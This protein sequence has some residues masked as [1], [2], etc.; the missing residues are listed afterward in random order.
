MLASLLI[1]FR[2]VLEA[3]LIVGIVLAATRGIAG[4]GAWIAGGIGGGVLGAA[5]L[6]I[7]AGALSDAFAGSGQEVFNAAVLSIA[8][9]MLGWHTLWMARHGREMAQHM[10]TMGVAVAIGSRSLFALAIVVASAVLRE[11]AE[12]VLFLYGIAAS[13]KEGWAPVLLGGVLGI[14]GGGLVSFLLYRGLVAI[15][16]GRLFGVTGWLVAL[17]A[18]GMASQAAAFLVKANLIPSWGD[19]IWDTSWLLSDG[20]ITGRALKAL[21][22]YSDRPMGVQLA[23]YL[24]VLAALVIGARLIGAMPSRTRPRAPANAGLP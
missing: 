18:A 20:S 22:G 10:K 7:F 1:V 19:E 5:V 21:I 2:E 24:A 9:V 12:V 13:A 23:V 3:G 8:V 6:A 4:R 15:P 16:L 11:G 14:G 17:M